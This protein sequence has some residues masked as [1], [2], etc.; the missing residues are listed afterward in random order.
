[1]S[2]A[3]ILD[4]LGAIGI[5]LNTSRLGGHRVRCPEC[6]KRGHDDAL[7]VRLDHDGAVWSCFRCGW[8]GRVAGEVREHRRPREVAQP[9]PRPASTVLPWPIWEAALPIEPGTVAARYL[10]AR[11]CALAPPDSDLRW[12]PAACHPCGRVGPALVALVTNAL[13]GERMTLH[14]TWL[15]PDGSGKA[16]IERPRLL[17]PGLP[18]AGGVVRLWPDEEVTTGLAIAEG[19]ETA[20]AAARSF[21]PVWAVVDAGN[22]AAFPVLDGIEALTIFSDHDRPNPKTGRRAGNEAAAVCARRWA[23]AGREAR[24]FLPPTEGTDIADLAVEAAL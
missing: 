9:K 16:A 8:S 6:N 1:M 17:W 4:R 23:E 11:G 24:I 13:T 15:R 19:I 18:K 14:R 10:K 2:A 3:S 21:A 7:G 5:R 12:T 22:L 20:L